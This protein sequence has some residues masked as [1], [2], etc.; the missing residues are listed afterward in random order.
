MAINFNTAPYYD[1]FDEAKK[2]YRILF[3][4]GRA[5]QAR[6][7]TQL[8]TALQNQ[9]SR[10]G[11]NIFKEGAI[12]IPGNLSLDTHL[13]YVK[14]TSTYNTTSTN[15]V[16]ASLVGRTLTGQNSNIKAIVVNYA[17]STSTDPAT[18][19]VRY[20]SSGING[21]TRV[22]G[23]S[24]V[25]VSDGATPISV[26][27]AGILATGFGSAFSV[28]AGVMFVK[29]VFAY[30][31][32]QTIL[33]SKYSST[34]TRSIGFKITETIVTSDDD[35]SIL[36]QAAGTYNYFAPG[37]DRYKLSLDLE[38][39]YVTSAGSDTADFIQLAIVEDGD[40][41][42]QKNTTDYNVIADTL[43][44]R[45]FDESGN[46]T[47]RPYKLEVIEHLQPANL[48]SRIGLYPATAGGNSDL[49]VNIIDPGKAY[50]LGYEITGTNS[51]YLTA[52][53]ARDFVTVTNSSISTETGN[54]VLVTGVTSMPDLL[55]LQKVS[56]YNRYTATAGTASGSLVGTARIRALEYVSGTI[57]TSSAVYKAYLFDV[58]MS[59]GF[60]FEKNVKQ[61]YFDNLTYTDFTANVVTSN[62]YISGS[63]ST[64]NGS[65]IITGTG[66]LFTLDVAAFDTLV[67]NSNVYT[68]QNVISDSIVYTTANI[69]GTVS[70]LKAT[71][72]SANIAL[73]S[74]A[75]YIYEFPYSTIKNVDPTNNETSY[76][77]RRTYDKTLAANVGTITAGTDEIFAPLT[78]TNYIGVRKSTGAYINLQTAGP[79][80][81][82][83][84][85]FSGSPTGKII[86]I[87]LPDFSSADIRLIT[88]VEKTSTS[89]DKRTKTLVSAATIDY[90]TNT[91]T[92]SS[93]TLG[94]SDIYRVSSIEM[95]ANAFGTPFYT[96]NAIDITDRYTIDNG[97]RK[98]HYDIG[99]V[100]LK[101]GYP[102]ATGPIRI[103][104]DY[105]THSTG[106]F[107]SVTSYTNSITYDE[108][109]PFVDGTKTYQ[110]RDCIDFRSKIDSGGLTFT[111]PG[112]FISSEVTFVTDYSY[113]LPRTDKVILD[114]AGQIKI[115]NGISSL[116]PT[117]PA[118]PQNAM[119]LYVY[120]Q[121]AY[122]F[123]AKT[124]IDIT[125]IENKRFTMRDIGRIEDRVKNLEYYTT[126]SLLE[127]DTAAFQ[128]KDALGFDRF[129]N[130][131]IV[132][133][134]TGHRVGNALDPDYSIAMDFKAGEVRPTFD[135]RN[136]KLSELATTNNER[137][138]SKYTR[139]G[140]LVSL[141][142]SSDI[143]VKNSAATRTENV[144]PFQVSNYIG[145]VEL[146]PPSDIWFDTNRLPDLHTDVEGNYST[147]DPSS[148]AKATYETIWNN[149]SDVWYGGLVTDQLERTG[150]TYGSLTTTSST[151]SD[152][153]ISKVLIPKM[154]SID[155]KFAAYGLKPNTA[156]QVYFNDYKVTNQC[157]GNGSATGDFLSDFI[158]NKGKIVT[159][160]RGVV[161]GTFNYD[162]SRLD[163]TTGSKIFRLSDS[164]TNGDAS[165]SA[166]AV[167]TAS[168]EITNV[169][170]ETVSTRNVYRSAE[171]VVE[172][173]DK[174]VVATTMPAQITVI[175]TPAAV[176]TT[177]TATIE[178]VSVV[179]PEAYNLTSTEVLANTTN[180]S[181]VYS[182]CTTAVVETVETGIPA[183][184]TTNTVI[185]SVVTIAEPVVPDLSQTPSPLT[186]VAS[187]GYGQIST[188]LRP[189]DS[190][191]SL[192]PTIGW[193]TTFTVTSTSTDALTV[194]VSNTAK[195]SNINPP[196]I[197]PSSFTLAAG[198]SRTVEATFISPHSDGD[199]DVSFGAVAVG[200]GGTYPEHVYTGRIIITDPPPVEII[201]PSGNT[202]VTVTVEPVIEVLDQ[203]VTPVVVTTPVVEV[204]P[205]V[206]NR[207]TIPTIAEVVYACLFN[208]YPDAEG[209]KYWEDQGAWSTIV[210][211][212]QD[213][214]TDCN[215]FSFY[216]SNT[217]LMYEAF[218]GGAWQTSSKTQAAWV[219]MEQ[220]ANAGI[221]SGFGLEGATV[222]EFFGLPV[223]NPSNQALACL[224][225]ILGAFG[226]ATSPWPTPVVVVVAAAV[227]AAIDPPAQIPAI[228]PDAIEIP[229]EPIFTP[230]FEDEIPPR[231][232]R[233]GDMLREARWDIDPL[234][235]TFI[236]SGDSPLILTKLDLFFYE[237]D[238]NQPM[239][240]EIRTVVNGTPTQTVVP[241]SRVTVFPSQII[242]SAD[243][244]VATTVI[245]DG[246][247]YLEPGEYSIVLKSNS[248]YH[249]VWI[250]QVGEIDVITGK[251]VQE[252][253]FVGVLFK[254]QNASTWTAD[255]MQDLKFNLYYAK[256]NTND[257]ATVDFVLDQSLF[258]Y[259]TL[260][261]SPL[262]IYPSPNRTM[263]IYHDNHGLTTSSTAKITG[264]RSLNGNTTSSSTLY[265][266]NV[267][268]INNVEFNVSNVQLNSYTI[269]LP[270]APD[271]NIT[272]RT[273]IGTGGILAFQDLTFDAIYPAVS[274]IEH[275]DT[276]VQ[277]GAR[278]TRQAGYAVDSYFTD[279]TSSKIEELDS[280]AVISNRINTTNHVTGST[281]F[282]LRVSLST[283][284]ALVSPIVDMDQVSALFVKN[285][286][287]NP[288]YSSVTST[289]DIITIAPSRTDISF[290]NL[291]TTTGYVNLQTALDKGNAS[292]I[293]NG[294][295]VI[296]TGSASNNG[297]FRVIS[298]DNTG[299]NVKVNG[300]I[301][302]EAPGSTVTVK[303]GAAFVAEE[304][305]TGG[306]ALSKYITKQI[307]FVNPSTSINLR[308][309]IAKPIGAYVKLYY[310]T[311]LQGE[312]AALS[313]KEYTEM[314]DLVIPDSLGGEYFEVTKQIDSLS[315]FQS[316][317]F[318]IVLL[319]DNTAA[320]P[321]CKNLRAVI[322]A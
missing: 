259:K 109:P 39:R 168:G 306:S 120:K 2:F 179:T 73:Q 164:T 162:S 23:N 30:F 256:F 282:V 126:L 62:A 258:E 70:S 203:T 124:D 64:T 80:G 108:I 210:A 59:T 107:F 311:L 270:T 215:F 209:A 321:K 299:Q 110:L 254:S 96:N 265:G 322:L 292:S 119:A 241:F 284:S 112:D 166:E 195:P 148:K 255:Q 63:V 174:V 122:V 170:N 114:S 158:Y 196:V 171:T 147:L 312:T 260:E 205:A 161:T 156:L 221:A 24:E 213:N 131:F 175:E 89:A 289:E 38:I 285:R 185:T 262:E 300:A 128:V 310:K 238:E 49:Y 106:D 152:V 313:N 193:K 186:I 229:L 68:V 55:T 246:L 71:K 41:V 249:R 180:I 56:L 139:T 173:R 45:T 34:V 291:S 82:S 130:G 235:Q 257:V 32:D 298:V 316:I 8:Q 146:D 236:I 302:T 144:N 252:Q 160:S 269:T 77:T 104:F 194:I 182:S 14:L 278:L 140:N 309:D 9:I 251:K 204:S 184:Q 279:L 155:I 181:V 296:I 21:S 318:K 253:P 314:T 75:A 149:W 263:R 277:I 199:Y 60:T 115:I 95:S 145:V 94:Q 234:A 225:A 100:V 98:T 295:N 189:G 50:V 266:I 116:T 5:V 101:P 294:S 1:N 6:E 172:H 12:V 290:T 230:D 245:F 54:Y 208:R 239:F 83:A 207:Y 237:K 224:S 320:V 57:G 142:Y 10:F 271:A 151:S 267:E 66:T 88:T 3:R 127:T 226:T 81:G 280:T 159:D 218:N 198:A 286:I 17:E 40:L 177:V 46:Y 248:L 44:R 111:N 69:V 136:F 43:A 201:A 18:I 303:N 15:T 141:P 190:R 93:L 317:I 35:T 304:A 247:V 51:K 91:A 26:Q 176:S 87:N 274:H 90:T 4:P 243:G 37:A 154:R 305:P 133:N 232:S 183:S 86:T 85:T 33:V 261:Y 117:E 52:S 178:T 288:T 275:A 72:Q 242:T 165:T 216:G 272:Q 137:S 217:V 211:A 11:Q 58:T 220:I 25:L 123:N 7:L 293:V 276:K 22:F 121:K 250:S 125:P 105:F 308:L 19:Y 169:R 13:N 53:K 228:I 102:A 97:Q 103:T 16:L 197:T 315:A 61:I 134:F 231:W 74:K 268:T 48:T 138:S 297:S 47:V 223:Y 192:D 273:R 150:T 187:T 264:I 67:V 167:F 113:Y 129:K 76:Y 92:A 188:E 36:D 214:T 157:V 244:S 163:L 206:V 240:V 202:T 78:A 65:N 99:S 20:T 283:N 319:S 31:E 118:T 191:Q 27:A 79:A 307:D 135:Q 219:A 200:Y 281:P 28:T 301:V 42:K 233:R 222:D 212:T 29:N 132:D 84:I 143:F 153:V 287:N 227:A